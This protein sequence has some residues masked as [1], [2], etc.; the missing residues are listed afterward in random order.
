[1]VQIKQKAGSGS[2]F[3]FLGAFGVETTVGL[4]FSEFSQVVWSRLNSACSTALVKCLEKIAQ[5]FG[6][7]IL[8]I[9]KI[10]S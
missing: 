7:S 2:K 4:F 6:Y 1:M 5:N 10:A 3:H 8:P 9:Q